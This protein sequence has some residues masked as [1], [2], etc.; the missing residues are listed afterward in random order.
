MPRPPG[1]PPHQAELYAVEDP[2]DGEA[3]EQD[4][5]GQQ[6]QRRVQA[7]RLQPG[8]PHLR[9][10]CVCVGGVDLCPCCEGWEGSDARPRLRFSAGPRPATHLA[11][12]FLGW[13]GP[14][15]GT[16]QLGALWPSLERCWWCSVLTVFTFY[17][18]LNTGTPVTA[19]I[20]SLMAR[21]VSPPPPQPAA[22]TDLIITISLTNGG[23]SLA[24][25]DRDKLV[26]SSTETPSIRQRRGEESADGRG[27]VVCFG[28]R[29]PSGGRVVFVLVACLIL[30]SILYPCLTGI[31]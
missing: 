10:S 5:A 29:V 19:A 1:H 12:N 24:K 28:G 31:M 26:P 30:P 13:S 8:L 7:A 21:S 23:C 27:A 2:L 3:G 15:L 25:P 16:W 4:H 14:R 11:A 9:G 22:I 6:Q 20:N 18:W 17:L